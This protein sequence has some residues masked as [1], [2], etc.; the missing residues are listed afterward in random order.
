MEWTGLFG[1]IPFLALVVLLLAR[2]FSIARWMRR[3]GWPSNPSVLLAAIV[4]A[5]LLDAV[6]EDWLFAPGYHLCILVWTCAFML[7]DLAPP[8]IS[9]FSPLCTAVAVGQTQ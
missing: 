3:S 4:L 8:V 6:F 2:T 1:C 5:G 7:M 9:R